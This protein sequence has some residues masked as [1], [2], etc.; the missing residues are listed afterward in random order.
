[1]KRFLK[2]LLWALIAAV[3]V[4]TFVYLFNNSKPKAVTYDILNP[5]TTTIERA[6]VLTGKIEPRDEIEIKP[7]I[8]GIISEVNIEPGDI[9][10]EGD[11]IAKI[12]VIPDDSQLNSARNRLDIAKLTLS[13]AESV[14]NRTKELYDKKYASRE[15]FEQA[16]TEYLKAKEEVAS[17]AD[18]LS[19]VKEGVSKY[20][21][22][23]S[24]T[25]V[26]ATITGQVLEVPVKVG[27]SVIQ[28]NTMNDGTTVAK[29]ADM[30]NLIFKG[31]VD[32]TEVGLLR[33]GMPMVITI[34]ALPDVTYD[35]EIEYIAPK[36]TESN[37]SN[38]F[39]IK[40]AIKVEPGVELRAGYSANASVVLQ[41]A[42]DVL[43]VPEVTVEWQ[44][45]STYVYVLTAETQEQTFR[46]TPI[47]TGIS[48]GVNVQVTGGINETDRLRG[49]RQD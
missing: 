41:K 38:T 24:N 13:Q 8:S 1:M 35:G 18:A 25:L 20:N 17:A 44:G 14:F 34:G 39:E 12:K 11:V 49:N 43:T 2:I 5:S 45:D 47:T 33:Q 26:R 4:G 10:H 3:F 42:A 7:Q 9:V 30:N 27:S 22:Q 6:T 48:D 19:I 36:S 37:G 23:Q 31:K 21:A 16:Q 15:E 40:A 28:A 46:R 32:E 29:V